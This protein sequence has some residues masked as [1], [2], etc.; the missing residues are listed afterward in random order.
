MAG[1]STGIN[2][3]LSRYPS[4]SFVKGGAKVVCSL[5]GHEMPRKLDALQAYVK[6]KKFNR[7]NQGDK[8][9][10]AQYEPHLVSCEDKDYSKK[11]YCNLTQRYVNKIPEHVERHVKGKRFQTELKRYEECQRNGREYK[12]R[13][14]SQRKDKKEADSVRS[15][16][17]EEMDIGFVPSD[18]EEDEEKDL[19]DRE[20]NMEDLFPVDEFPREEYENRESTSSS[21]HQ[22]IETQE[23]RGRKGSKE[24]KR[25]A[26][27]HKTPRVNSSKSKKLRNPKFKSAHRQTHVQKQPKKAAKKKPPVNE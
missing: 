19:D 8:Y 16:D 18:S 15:D 11:L 4:L 26:L 2:E 20:D 7:L 5:T 9:N 3:F 21:A 24:R 6:G 22:R 17:E 1:S 27:M 13:R 25:G 10:F 14:K 12:S 23:A